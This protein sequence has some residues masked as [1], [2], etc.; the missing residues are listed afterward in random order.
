VWSLVPAVARHYFVHLGLVYAAQ[1]SPDSG[2][3]LTVSKVQGLRVWEGKTGNELFRRPLFVTLYH[4]DLYLDVFLPASF[5]ADGQQILGYTRDKEGIQVTVW[6]AR[7]GA[8]VVKT[9]GQSHDIRS[10]VFSSSGASILTSSEDK[11]A[12]LWSAKTGEQIQVFEGHEKAVHNAVFLGGDA[13]VVTSSADHTARVWE[14]ATGNELLRLQHQGEVNYALASE[15]G[16]RI[17]TKW[18]TQIVSQGRL[19]MKYHA[20]LWNAQTG[21]IIK[22]LDL[23]E[24]A[25]IALFVPATNT[26]FLTPERTCLVDATTGTLI[27]EY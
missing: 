10:A 21:E 6:D 1:F 3:V 5:R 18:Q 7:S 19:A 9:R 2:L 12:R 4:A 20:T 27:R 25:A 16:T 14:A 11:T 17:L 22:T 15:D 23:R 26:V 13:K 8:E 24:N